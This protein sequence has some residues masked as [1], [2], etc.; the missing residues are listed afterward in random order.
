VQS[1]RA[2]ALHR[3][4]LPPWATEAHLRFGHRVRWRYNG[5]RLTDKSTA[6]ILYSSPDRP[7]PGSAKVCSLRT[8]CSASESKY[9]ASRIVGAICLVCTGVLIT[10]RPRLGFETNSA[11]FVSASLKPPCSANFFLESGNGASPADGS[12]YLNGG[13]AHHAQPTGTTNGL[14]CLTFLRKI[15]GA[16]PCSSSP[17]VAGR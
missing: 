2:R 10:L 12:N 5:L 1:S 17:Y 9:N 8:A 11:T 15:L 7:N 16:R 6:T 4:D 14:K 3:R 13:I